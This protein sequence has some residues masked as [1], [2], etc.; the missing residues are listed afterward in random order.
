M[1][2]GV[3]FTNPGELDGT[4]QEVAAKA[5]TD[6]L[7]HAHRLREHLA[8]VELQVRNGVMQAPVEGLES[9][10]PADPH[11]YWVVSRDARVWAAA[12]QYADALSKALALLVKLQAE[13]KRAILTESSPSV[14]QDEGGQRPSA[15]GP[16][17]GD[18]TSSTKGSNA[19]T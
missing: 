16:R 18:D 3:R 1:T 12:I 15:R 17:V 11:E 8:D 5:T 6:A 19:S 7:R 9:S 2:Q 10:V 13:A 14:G 4:P